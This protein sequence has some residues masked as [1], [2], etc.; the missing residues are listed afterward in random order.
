MVAPS[1]GGGSAPQDRAVKRRDLT[2]TVTPGC[3]PGAA[4]FTGK[5]S[6]EPKAREAKLEQFAKGVDEKRRS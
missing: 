1:E 3:A 6:E 5:R 2:A 4:Q